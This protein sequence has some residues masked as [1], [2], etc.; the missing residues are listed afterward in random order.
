MSQLQMWITGIVV[1]VALGTG[2]A[3]AGSD[4]GARAGGWSVFAVCVAA[5]FVIN[6][7]VFVPSW[8]AHTEKYFDLTGSL[9][10]LTVT[11]LA[12]ALSPDLDLRAWLAAGLVA[13]WAARLGS[14]LFRRMDI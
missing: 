1:S 3:L 7:V 5:A 11:A 6:W 8:F 10:Y 12:V 9:T 13:I 14:F 2:L 4:D